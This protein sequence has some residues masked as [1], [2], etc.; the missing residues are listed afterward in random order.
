MVGPYIYIL[1]ASLSSS[2]D[3]LRI[4][5]LAERLK[6]NLK[7]FQIYKARLRTWDKNIHLSHSVTPAVTLVCNAAVK[8]KSLYKNKR[9]KVTRTKRTEYKK[10][11]NKRMPFRHF[12]R[13]MV[14]ETY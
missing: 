2:S 13:F 9:Y 7:K 6:V 3:V 5:L 4:I 8:D 12:P 1:D 11:L 14:F 10:S